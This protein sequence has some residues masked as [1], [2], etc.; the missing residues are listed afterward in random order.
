MSRMEDSCCG[1]ACG[2]ACWPLLCRIFSSLD[3]SGLW[4]ETLRGDRCGFV[5][6]YPNRFGRGVGWKMALFGP[7]GFISDGQGIGILAAE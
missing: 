6:F 5:R 7:S 3:V 2:W 4:I 1:A